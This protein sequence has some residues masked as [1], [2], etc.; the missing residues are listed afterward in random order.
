MNLGV[1]TVYL[2]ISHPI[3]RHG[4][5]IC[6]SSRLNSQT[7]NSILP[8]L[9]TELSTAQDVPQGPGKLQFQTPCVSAILSL[10]ILQP[11]QQDQASGVLEFRHKKRAYF[12]TPFSQPNILGSIRL[13]GQTHSL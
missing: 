12:H 13:L 3:E 10:M 7:P 6:K 4:S 5:H 9:S 11:G 2:V 8:T 1:K